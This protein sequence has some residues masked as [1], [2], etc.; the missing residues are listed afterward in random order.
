MAIEHGQT[1]PVTVPNGSNKPQLPSIQPARAPRK[2][3]VRTTSS[4]KEFFTERWRRHYALEFS[5]CDSWWEGRSDHADDPCC[6]EAMAWLNEPDDHAFEFQGVSCAMSRDS[7]GCWRAKL[8]IPQ[9]FKLSHL[10]RDCST[11][12]ERSRLLGRFEVHGGVT[13][14]K[15]V[16]TGCVLGFDCAHDDGRMRNPDLYPNSLLLRIRPPPA[17]V[18]RT[19]E[20]CRDQARRLMTQVVSM[21]V[22]DRDERISIVH[23][24][25]WVG[26][27]FPG[28]TIDVRGQSPRMIFDLGSGVGSTDI[29]ALLRDF[30]RH[31]AELIDETRGSA[32]ESDGFGGVVEGRIASSGYR[33]AADALDRVVRTMDRKFSSQTALDAIDE[34]MQ[35]RHITTD[36][37]PPVHPQGW[38]DNRQSDLADAAD[39]EWRERF[40]GI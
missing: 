36:R 39:P 3:S 31:Q 4:T 15:T 14:A 28:C 33:S 17:A 19:F 29:L 32:A 21:G 22:V 8:T 40:V 2:T 38:S 26:D 37:Q 1:K 34:G 13:L 11:G 12:A 30:Y 9:H 6:P 25:N 27:L 35:P 20:F 18:Y 5:D 10:L 7:N 23:R 16:P 24:W